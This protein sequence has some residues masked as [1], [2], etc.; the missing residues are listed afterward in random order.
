ML[1]PGVILRRIILSA[2]LSSVGQSFSGGRGFFGLSAV[3]V[4]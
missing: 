3:A 4:T 1:T 2:S